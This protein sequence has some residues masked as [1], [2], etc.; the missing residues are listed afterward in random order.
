VGGSSLGRDTAGF[1]CCISFCNASRDCFGLACS[2]GVN[3]SLIL[4]DLPNFVY[5]DCPLTNASQAAIL[6]AVLLPAIYEN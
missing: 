1:C 6:N 4:T 3:Q 5:V 2:S